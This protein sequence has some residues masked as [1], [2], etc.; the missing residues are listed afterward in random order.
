FVGHKA[1]THVDWDESHGVVSEDVDHFDGYGVA[2]R[3]VI[4][5]EGGRQFQAAVLAGAEA[6]PFVLEDIAAGPAFGKAI[7]VYDSVFALA[8]FVELA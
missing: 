2:A 6:L 7:L 3:P 1:L 5:V 4:G 8:D